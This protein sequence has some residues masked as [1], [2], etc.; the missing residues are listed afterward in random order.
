MAAD[1]CIRAGRTAAW[2]A[3]DG[4]DGTI[5]IR[6]AGGVYVTTAT[7]RWLLVTGPRAPLGP[8]SLQLARGVPARW[9]PGDPVRVRSGLL[10]IGRD[11]VELTGAAV[12]PRQILPACVPDAPEA[13]ARA[14]AA[15]PTPPAD[16][17]SGIAALARGD[18]RMAVSAL[19][20][21]G[22]GLT[23]A[24]DDILAGYCAW[25]AADAASDPILLLEL[26][27][28]RASPLGLA[29][30]RCAV[31]GDVVDAAARLM[32]AVRSADADLVARRAP[33]LG[34][35]GASSGAAMVWG[36]DAAQ[37]RRALEGAVPPPRY[38]TDAAYHAYPR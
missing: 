5:A 35:W 38:P 21:R 29:Y 12:E 1:R 14:C 27:G 13:M 18:L 30:L 16:L 4:L 32:A 7:G 33:A 8:L 23:P 17:V 19:A 24:G 36:M 34:G 6:L 37:R 26:A 28:A 31:R 9:R 10:A 20:G 3:G 25:R 2:V 22:S 11:H 15:L